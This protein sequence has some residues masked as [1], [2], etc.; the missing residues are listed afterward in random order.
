[1][2]FIIPQRPSREISTR[3]WNISNPAA[4]Q[5]FG[6]VSEEGEPVQDAFHYRGG[7]CLTDAA[8]LRKRYEEA[9]SFEKLSGNWYYA[10]IFYPH[11]GHFLTES[12]HRLQCLLS[13]DNCPDGIIF[14]KSPMQGSFDYDPLSLPYV[15]FIF[16]EFFALD[17]SRIIFTESFLHIESLE[18][19]E[20]NSQLGICPDKTYLD[21]LR[22][23][24]TDVASRMHWPQDRDRTIF[25]SRRQYLKSG[26]MLGMSAVETAL[27]K[28]GV[29]I[30]TPESLTVA[31][32]I[33]NFREAS[34]L[35]C[36]AGSALHILDAIGPQ[37]VDLVV[38]SRR[39]FD[40]NY[41][42]NLYKGRVK[43]VQVY[44]LVL[45]IHAYTRTR[46]GEGHS[47]AHPKRLYDFLTRLG[48]ELN[49]KAFFDDLVNATSQD[50]LD[51]GLSFVA[52]K[53]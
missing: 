12:I 11:F 36:E 52:K 49:E 16:E 37:N 48:L 8:A 5:A 9:D 35:Y 23:R 21:F 20:Q 41:W 27:R 10:G 2:P 14:L 34:T 18:I 7:R 4:T 45:P 44:D 28:N 38:F 39:G 50:F 3:N 46:A 17:P 6:V 31:E 40:S 24:E 30:L 19:G 25:L 33:R 26:R 43:S 42:K 29:E 53:D 47:L 32:Q 13:G 1:M 51:L 15:Q 22:S